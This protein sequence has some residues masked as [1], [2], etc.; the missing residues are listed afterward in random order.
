MD[1]HMTG[2]HAAKT[3]ITCPHT[4][5]TAPPDFVDR[6]KISQNPGT[7]LMSIAFFVCSAEML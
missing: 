4:H 2:R 3:G 6:F 7:K 1:G 5:A